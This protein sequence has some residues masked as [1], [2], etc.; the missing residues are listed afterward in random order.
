MQFSVRQKYILFHIYI[1]WSLHAE[2]N[3]IITSIW[4]LF[5]LGTKEIILNHTVWQVIRRPKFPH[6]LKGLHQERWGGERQLLLSCRTNP[7][8]YTCRLAASSVGLLCSPGQLSTASAWKNYS[9]SRKRNFLLR[10]WQLFS[11][12]LMVKNVPLVSKYLMGM[13]LQN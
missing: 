13:R 3:T 1:Q 7:V 9:G 4:N 2:C 12:L 8:L 5:L 6:E 11:I 10:L